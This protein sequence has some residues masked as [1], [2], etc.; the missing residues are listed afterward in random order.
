MNKFFRIVWVIIQHTLLL[1][2]MLISAIWDTIV[3]IKHKGSVGDCW[4]GMIDAIGDLHK[5]EIDFI[6]NK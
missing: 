1:P 3:T 6:N 4:K 5:S 2:V